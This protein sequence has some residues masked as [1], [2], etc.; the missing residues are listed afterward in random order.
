MPT[1]ILRTHDKQIYLEESR[2]DQPKEI[3]KALAALAAQSGVVRH[4]SVVR[5]LGCASGEFLYYLSRQFPAAELHGCDVLPE[6]IAKAKQAVPGVHF[7]QG[8]VLDRSILPEAST[9][10]AFLAGVLSIFDEFETCLSNL[11][12]WTRP[13][14]RIYV[15]GMFNPYPL[16]VWVTYRKAEGSDPDHREPGWNIFSEVSISRYL[17]SI[18]GEGKHTFTPYDMPIDLPPNPHDP[19]RTWT[20]RDSDDRRL[21]TNGLCLICPLQILEIRP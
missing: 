13:G 2:Y 9:D 18:L 16:D 4:G 20:F 7:E 11:L 15:E 1:K 21:L 17:D 19:V 3:F 8:S 10:V 6:L 14:G 5:D 12:Y